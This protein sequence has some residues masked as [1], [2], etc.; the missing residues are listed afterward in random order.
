MKHLI[1]FVVLIL[2]LPAC[3]S[4]APETARDY[5]QDRTRS[6]EP[7]STDG[8][9]PAQ[10]ANDEAGPSQTPQQKSA[11]N[12][13]FVGRRVFETRP[14]VTGTGTPHRFVEIM[15]NGDVFFQYGQQNAKAGTMTG[16]RYFAGKFRR[17]LKCEFKDLGDTRYYVIGK[18]S[19]VELDADGKRLMSEDCCTGEK[20]DLETQCGCEGKLFD[21]GSAPDPG[22]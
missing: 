10:L 3:N 16:E 20:I 22:I 7:V 2:T 9:Q 5:S 18:T 13:P 19:I 11:G 1:F 15:P 8:E 21:P 12:L 4:E 6:E 17:V 14:A